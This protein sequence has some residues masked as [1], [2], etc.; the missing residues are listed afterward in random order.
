[1]TRSLPNFPILPIN[2]EIEKTAKRLRKAA[3]E[4]ANL[5]GNPSSSSDTTRELD[6]SSFYFPELSDP[7]AS[8]SGDMG[9]ANRTLKELAAQDLNY[10]PLGIVYPEQG[11]ILS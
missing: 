7:T 2:P 8:V 6:N 11:V 5:S 3:R 10:Q 1:M 4:G 9:E